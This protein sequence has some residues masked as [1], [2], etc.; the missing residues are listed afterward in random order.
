MIA[1]AEDQRRPGS[2]E[3]TRANQQIPSLQGTQV[4]CHQQRCSLA[5]N[6][7]LKHVYGCESGH[8]SYNFMLFAV[9]KDTLSC[10]GNE[11]GAPDIATGEELTS[12]KQYGCRSSVSILDNLG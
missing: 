6:L 11:R 4:L 9:I 5:S 1:Q 10:A 2:L 3:N 7:E 8:S 12:Y